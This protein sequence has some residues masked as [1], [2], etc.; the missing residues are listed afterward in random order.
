M[1]CEQFISNNKSF[2]SLVLT[3]R[4]VKQKTQGQEAFVL[5]HLGETKRLPLPA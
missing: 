3:N 5:I 1:L 4:Q 2:E